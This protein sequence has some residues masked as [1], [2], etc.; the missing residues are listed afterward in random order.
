MLSPV[1]TPFIKSS[2]ISVMARGMVERVLNPEQLDEW[3]DTTAKEQYTKDLLFS[4]LFNLMSQVVQGSQRSI[5]AA[6]QTSKEDI[7]VSIT[8]IYNKLN[9]ME[10]STSAALVRYAAEQVEPII[11][12]L[13][14]KQNSPLPG[15]RIKLL[16]GNCIEK[17][18]HRIKELRSIAA[19]PL[20][21]KSLVV[22]DPMLHLPIDVFPCED[23]HAQERSMLKT[24][25]ETIVADDVWIADRNFCVVEFTCGID[26]RDAWFI[27]REHGNYPFELIGKGKYIGK[28]ETGAV[29]EQP[30]RVRDEAGE[31]HPFRRIRVKLKGETRDGDTEILIITNLSKSAANAK[32]VARLYRDRWTIETAFQR[33]A[34]YLNS[35]INTLGYPRAALFGFCVALVAYI[36]MSVVKAALGSVHG[37][38]FIDQNVSGY[39]V[40]NEIEGV[41]QGMMI[42]I[43][44]EH[45]VVFRD[46]P[47][48]D[49][50]RLLKKP[51]VS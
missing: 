24:V 27:I 34:E 50:V 33:L 17:S 20:P 7:T 4:T 32:T 11:Q 42:V 2:P 9:G 51:K 46:M 23:G 49:L 30:I 47:T 1:F 3:F 25:L 28:I 48:G 14:G 5:H 16:D 37:I 21:G 12:K 31:E 38:D 8:S 10:P 18:H 29:Y 43:D 13:L 40:A 41:Y 36:G 39:Y 22:Y 44:V 35:E 6:F 45:W 26:K 15:K 19:G